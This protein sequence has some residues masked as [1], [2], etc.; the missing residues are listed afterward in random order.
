MPKIA[1]LMILTLRDF[2]G[3][4]HDFRRAGN[5]MRLVTYF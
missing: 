2:R 3:T 5:E 1:A 4:P